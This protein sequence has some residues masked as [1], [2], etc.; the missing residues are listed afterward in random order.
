MIIVEVYLLSHYGLWISHY[1]SFTEN[2]THVYREEIE[3]GS[4]PHIILCIWTVGIALFDALQ[5]AQFIFGYI[6]RKREKSSNASS[7]ATCQCTGREPNK[8]ETYSCCGPCFYTFIAVFI[9]LLLGGAKVSLAIFM[10]NRKA[11]LDEVYLTYCVLEAGHIFLDVSLRAFM[12]GEMYK[13]R[14]VWT[15]EAT[16]SGADN[17]LGRGQSVNNEAKKGFVKELEDYRER[18]NEAKYLLY[19]FTVW[20]LTPWI[21][22]LVITSINPHY[23]LAPWTDSSS[24]IDNLSRAFHLINVAYRTLLLLLQYAFALKVNQYHRDYYINMRHRV[25]LKCEQDQEYRLEASQFMNSM[26]F[27]DDFNFYPTFLSINPRIAVD[28]PLYVILLVLGVIVNTSEQLF[29]LDS[30]FD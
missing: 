26:Y 12:L 2:A 10:E 20:F 19:P 21:V 8:K 5:Y 23:L 14:H 6:L 13:I 30:D 4:Y 18:G 28:G 29:H 27:H 1:G 17:N 11:N 9:L 3:T 16:Q 15:E 22:Y 25:T 7:A 24:R